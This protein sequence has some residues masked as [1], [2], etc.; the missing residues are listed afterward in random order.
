MRREGLKRFRTVQRMRSRNAVAQDLGSRVSRS[1]LDLKRG[2]T[3]KTWKK[4][5]RLSEPKESSEEEEDDR[6]VMCSSLTVCQ[7]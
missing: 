1:C 3:E 5:K 4:N 2:S 7:N 6:E